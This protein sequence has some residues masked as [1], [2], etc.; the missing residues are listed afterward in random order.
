MV[1]PSVAAALYRKDESGREIAG[2][3]LD[4]EPMDEHPGAAI[5]AAPV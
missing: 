3:V 5:E 4:V 2:W 1:R